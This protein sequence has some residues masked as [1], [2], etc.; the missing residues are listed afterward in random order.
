MKIYIGADHR[1]FSLKE[2]LKNWLTSLGHEVVDCGAASLNPSDDYPDFAFAVA[3]NVVREEGS[4]GVVACGSSIGVTIAA[5]KVKGARCSPGL[6]PAE[7]AR[8]REDDDTNI[9]ALSADYLSE[10]EAQKMVTAFLETP[11][12][13]EENHVRRLKKIGERENHG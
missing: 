1:G 3:D 2:N 10:D 6:S 4:R 11:F 5:N 12:K 8:G 13:A 9:L 7:I